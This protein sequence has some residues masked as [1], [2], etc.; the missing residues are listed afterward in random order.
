MRWFVG[1]LF[2]TTLFLLLKGVGLFTPQSITFN[3]KVHFALPFGH[4]ISYAVNENTPT[5]IGCGIVPRCHKEIEGNVTH[6]R[7]GVWFESLTGADSYMTVT[8]ES[9]FMP[10]AKPYK[11]CLMY[12]KSLNNLACSTTPRSEVLLRRGSYTIKVV[13]N[14]Q[15]VMQQSVEVICRE[16]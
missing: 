9:V 12:K 7:F 6:S 14:S 16:E 10:Q 3:H 8:Q 13:S 5:T 1:T 4:T 15:E 11:A 2:V